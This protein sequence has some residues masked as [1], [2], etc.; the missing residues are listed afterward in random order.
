MLHERVVIGPNTRRRMDSSTPGQTTPPAW[1]S[2]EEADMIPVAEGFNAIPRNTPFRSPDPTPARVF[3]PLVRLVLGV[4][5]AESVRSLVSWRSS[6]ALQA[7][8]SGLPVPLNVLLGGFTL[9][10]GERPGRGVPK[11]TAARSDMTRQNVMMIVKRTAMAMR[12]LDSLSWKGTGGRAK[13]EQPDLGG[14]RCSA[15]G[16]RGGS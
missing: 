7:G 8:P 2:A 5:G 3:L 10:R 12:M 9:V 14:G 4:H 16:S 15:K 13:L 1:G 11:C 6:S